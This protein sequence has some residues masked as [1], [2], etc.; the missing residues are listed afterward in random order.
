MPVVGRATGWV[1]LTAQ[2][3]WVGQNG[4]GQCYLDDSFL[5]EYQYSFVPSSASLNRVDPSY[6]VDVMFR[7][8]TST[9]L[10]PKENIIV[11]TVGGTD[12]LS[13]PEGN[14]TVI[15]EICPPGTYI[16]C[17]T[18]PLSHLPNTP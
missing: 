14:F 16:P 7:V 13:N 11:R 1:W 12:T 8:L 3:G 4:C 5:Q 18:L 10:P 2:S 9:E 6:R 15:P 17:H